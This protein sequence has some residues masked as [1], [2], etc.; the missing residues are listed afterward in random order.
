[1]MYHFML[2]LRGASVAPSAGA[3]CCGSLA[4]LVAVWF[5]SSSC[6]IT[7]LLPGQL[8]LSPCARRLLVMSPEVA[9]QSA[10]GVLND[11]VDN[12][13]IQRK[14]EH[15]DDHDQSGGA[16]F[17]KGRRRHLA[18]FGAHIVVEGPDPFRPGFQPFSKAAAGCCN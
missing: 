5:F 2:G 14:D 18:H 16:N 9:E 11:V 6:I 4:V 8:S 17:F 3:A 13:E 15:R 10:H 1:M 7:M 12:S